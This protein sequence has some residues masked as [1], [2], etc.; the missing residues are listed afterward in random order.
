MEAEQ[1]TGTHARSVSDTEQD[2]VLAFRRMDDAFGF[3][4]R[5]PALF[6]LGDNRKPKSTSGA[7]AGS[8]APSNTAQNGSVFRRRRG[9]ALRCSAISLLYSRRGFF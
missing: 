1:F 3:F 5:E 7:L 9:L 6:V 4:L 8:L 2:L